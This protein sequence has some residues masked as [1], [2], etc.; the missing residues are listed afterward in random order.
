[1]KSINKRLMKIKHEIKLEHNKERKQE[2]DLNL[3]TKMSKYM[4][5]AFFI[6]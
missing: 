4:A 3:K 6:G 5:N 2:N 1:M